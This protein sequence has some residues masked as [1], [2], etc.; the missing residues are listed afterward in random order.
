MFPDPRASAHSKKFWRSELA[1]RAAAAAST[2]S[3]P[4]PWLEDAAMARGRVLE[5]L[6]L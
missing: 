2:R 4:A 5:P 6:W 1:S 3:S